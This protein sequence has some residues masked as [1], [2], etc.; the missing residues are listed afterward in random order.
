MCFAPPNSMFLHLMVLLSRSIPFLFPFPNFPLIYHSSFRHKQ[1]YS[2]FW[3]YWGLN[4]KLQASQVLYHLSHSLSPRQH[5]FR[6]VFLTFQ[7]RSC[8]LVIGFSHPSLHA[9]DSSR[10]YAMSM[11]MKTRSLLHKSII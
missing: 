5:F 4:S 2:L 6:K 9:K 11:D 10:P 1:Y 7:K 8:P 3:W